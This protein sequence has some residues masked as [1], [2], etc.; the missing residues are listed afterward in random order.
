MDGIFE[1]TGENQGMEDASKHQ[2]KA[3]SKILM[4]FYQFHI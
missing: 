2:Y 4:G 3:E 1:T